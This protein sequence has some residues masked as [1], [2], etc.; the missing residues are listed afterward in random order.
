MTYRYIYVLLHAANN[1]FLARQSR[2][3]GRV[4]GAE[5]RRWLTAS[6]GV[7]LSKSY[8]LSD[9]VYL[10]MQSRGFRGEARVMEAITWHARDGVWLGVFIAVALGALWLGR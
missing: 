2:V 7:L 3:V 6:M 10:A 5:Q 8:T 1:M 9:E 4:S